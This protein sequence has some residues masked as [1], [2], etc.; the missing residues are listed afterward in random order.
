[1]ARFRSINRAAAATALWVGMIPALAHAQ[2]VAPEDVW[3][4]NTIITGGKGYAPTPMGQVHYR[5][6][7]PRDTKVPFFLVHQ[8]P[9]SMM[10]FAEIQNI[11][12]G[13]GVRSIMIDT[14]G[15]G[16]SD[17]PK[18]MPTLD[19][20]ADNMVA[21]MDYLKLPKVAIAGHHTGAGIVTAFAGRHSDRLAAF[22][23]QGVPLLNTEDRLRL[24]N[25]KRPFDAQPQADGS[26]LTKQF[27]PPSAAHPE[28][29]SAKHL[30]FQTWMTI[31]VEQAGYNIFPV[32]YS[33]DLI[34]DAKAITV[35]GLIMS[36]AEDVVFKG[37]LLLKEL[38]PDFTYV[39]FSQ[40]NEDQMYL[41]PHEWVKIVTDFVN[42]HVK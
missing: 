33:Y 35:P 9:M 7:G 3:P 37:S 42:T 32:L 20:L 1:M 27:P 10:E 4:G 38:R 17:M 25:R 39:A 34:P 11:L 13:M 31:G 8:S 23:V 40:G 30:A 18:T 6:I 21:V 16:N 36:D 28:P 14:P 12:A 2:T 5:D 24:L 41:H 26:H 15:Y 29:P 19:Q 22:I